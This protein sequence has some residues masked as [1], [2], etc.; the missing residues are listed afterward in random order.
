MDKDVIIKNSKP[1]DFD[2]FAGP[3]LVRA[4]PAIEPQLEIWVSCLLGG[5]DAN[6]SYNESVSLRMTGSF[7]LPAMEKA[8][9]DL[10]QRHEALRS[11]FS[12]DGS[13]IC[14]YK[15]IPSKL[16]YEDISAK[17]HTDQE[18]YIAEFS[19]HNA[20]T[21]FDL[22]NGPLF[23]VALFKLGSEEHYLTLSAHHI[24]CDGW[25]LGILMQDLGKLYSA[26]TKGETPHLPEA[27]QLSKYALEHEQFSRSEQYKRIEQYWIDQFKD[28]VPVLN[29]PTD[30][31][32]PSV[33]T[34]KSHRDDYTID[35]ELIASIKKMGGKAGCS[36]VTT[37]LASFEVFLH[38]ITGQSDIVLGLP[39]AGQSATGN[40]ALVGHCVNLL[41]LRSH[42]K[43]DLSFVDYLKKRKK[44]ILDDYDHQQFTFGSLL[45]KLNI[46]RDPSRVPL[47]PVVFNIDMGLDDGVSFEGLKYKLIYNPREFENFE[48]F[49]NTTGSGQSL[50]LEWSYNT[51]LFKQATIKRMMDEF[52]SLL[53][54]VVATP[55]IRIKD[56]PLVSSKKLQAKLDLWNDTYADY[57]KEK[58]LPDLIS[59]VAKKFPEKTAIQ[60]GDQNI[61]YKNLEETSD[62]LAALLSDLQVGPG[63]IIGLAVDRSAEMLISLLAIMKSGAAYLPID[64]QYPQQRIEYMLQDSAA[65]ILLTSQKYK[66]RFHTGAKEILIEDAWKKLHDYSGK[67]IAQ[68]VTGN[69][70][71]YVLYTSGST[72][73]PKAVQIEHHNLVNFLL[74]MQK[75]PGVGS[76]DRLLAVTTISFDIAGLELYLPLISGAEV[77]I[78]D[79]D[80]AKDGRLLMEIVQKKNVTVMQAT[81]STWKMMLESGWNSKLPLKVLCGGE[82]LP[83]D[84]ADKLLSKCG[85]LWN[86]Y[87]PTE[88]TI[89][90]TVKQ[91]MPTDEFITIGHPIDNTQVYILDEYMKP[92]TEGAVGEIFIA[93]DGVARGYLNR[94][95]LTSERFPDNSISGKKGEKMYRTGD[96]GKFLENGEVQ[97]LGRIDHQVK[98]R[99]Y[100]IELGEIEQLLNKQK[101]IKESVVVAREEKLVAYIVPENINEKSGEL[102]KQPELSSVWKQALRES[103]PDYMVPSDFIVIKN[104]PLTPNGKIDRNALPKPEQQQ[105]GKARKYVAPRNETE[106]LVASI[107]A[108]LLEVENVSIYDDFFEIGGHSLI[109]A[110]AMI[111][112]ENETG[113]RLPLATLLEAP[114]VE[115]LSQLVNSDIPAVNWNSLVPI[116]TTGHKPPIYIVHGFGMNVLLFNN[117]AKNMDAEQPVYALQ[118]R[119]LNAD[120]K[121]F[122]NMEDIAAHYISEIIA[123]DPG[124]SY[125]L[126]G[127]SF[128]GIIAFEMAK[129]LKAMG[130]EISMLGMFDTY[131]DNYSDYFDPRLRKMTKKVRRQFPKF[132]F[133][134]KSLIK[135]PV[136]TVAYQA[137][138]VRGKFNRLLGKEQPTEML[139]ENDIKIGE[140]YDYA[141][142]NYKMT[143][144]DGVI[145][146]F[147]VKKR[148]YFLDDL[149]FL[150]WKPYTK[151]GVVVHEIAGDHKTFL[152]SPFDKEFGKVLQGVMDERAKVNEQVKDLRGKVVLKAV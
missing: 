56:I 65:K 57:P 81:P 40:Y 89:W 105:E 80:T 71:A 1:V 142:R 58:S 130:K 120:E 28:N 92:L 103:L 122:D 29:M 39:A 128:G 64:P 150:G 37:L 26:Y 149:E 124:P 4:V 102:Q 86:M 50:I 90:S 42:P 111:R 63:D 131:A 151:R 33:R 138:F 94:P 147:K 85:S 121:P 34:Y 24:I 46:P 15:E 47:V 84:L 27:L 136:G 2:P 83:K 137:D 77:I 66:K 69:D 11:V 118:A 91:I 44:N 17:N 108:E 79:M 62:R 10:V 41:P 60:F 51:E 9:H 43:G 74:S 146:L 32:R 72:G 49:L 88:T 133:I 97:C 3:E 82:A 96:L 114:T 8:L 145:D 68:K 52:E 135:N 12:G 143:P 129:Q 35:Q 22:L 109:A 23:R 100:R 98:I 139:T 21:A 20:E 75:T 53:K 107:W 125:A 54:V 132:M 152:F 116:K 106:K 93:G 70:V 144:Y 13:Q 119:G 61:S 48:I 45:K 134:L 115:K 127:Y 55:D 112:L 5:E 87:G 7:N 6:R 73:K 76:D 31:P 140:I 14:V 19:K 141:Y 123:Q 67:K 113:K 148:L 117:V 101:N 30:F 95:E 18:K 110:R 104:L 59:N 78:T 25:S 16:F 126:A 36:F 99:G 38:R